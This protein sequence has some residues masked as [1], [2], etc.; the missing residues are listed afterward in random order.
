[1]TF[2][3]L[4][5]EG[6]TST[7]DTLLLFANGRGARPQGGDRDRF[8]EAVT[9][10]C[11]DLA[12]AMAADAEGASHLVTI[13]VTGLRS[14]DEARRVGRAVRDTPW[15]K[16][17]LFAADPTGAPTVPGAGY[18]GV[19]F[20]K[21]DLPLW[22]GDALL[23]RAGTPQP[24]DLAAVSAYMRANRDLHVRLEF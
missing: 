18:G 14:D 20:E 7:N 24:L 15:V 11:A 1:K 16:T 12:R 21:K 5:V 2:N 3:C 23:S 17:P 9:A 13:D 4:S 6:H 19:E 8:G 22:L 10:V